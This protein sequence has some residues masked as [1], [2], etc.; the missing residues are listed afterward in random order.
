MLF[1]VIVPVKNE[2]NYIKSTVLSLLDL[3]DRGLGFEI[4]IVDGNSTDGTKQILVEEFG[5][6]P[7]VHLLSNP[8]GFTPNAFNIG[9]KAAKGEFIVIVGA[10]HKLDRNY[11]SLCIEDLEL[12][13]LLGVSGGYAVHQYQ[14][15]V[16]EAIATAMTSKFGVGANNFRAIKKSG[17]VDTVGTPVYRKGLFDEIGLFDENLI[18]NQD[19]E[20]NFRLHKA[21]Y[22]AWLNVNA[23]VEYIVRS[24][25]S[26]LW[27]Q[28]QQYGYWKVFVNKKH[29]SLTTIRQVIPALFVIYL[30]FL[31]F[32]VYFLKDICI[33]ILLPLFFYII[34]ILVVTKLGNFDIQR[35]FLLIRAYLTLHL[36]YGLGYLKGI[37]DFCILNR[38]PNENMSQL[39]R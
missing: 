14:G 21:G 36:S 25:F 11:V 8:K 2:V 28:Y 30:I 18:R 10:R 13:R 34:I 23:K 32:T 24:N 20:F 16:S 5:Y 38:L 12:N 6:N 29:Q 26:N 7:K 9:I 37:L 35:L 17:Y 22:K 33:L 15:V 4:L 3:D 27:K 31:P 19:D 39:S 1:S